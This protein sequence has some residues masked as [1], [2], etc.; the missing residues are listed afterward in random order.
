MFIVYISSSS[1]PKSSSGKSP[2]VTSLG[3]INPP[4][5]GGHVKY[6]FPATLEMENKQQL[7]SLDMKVGM[8]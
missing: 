8:T 3:L 1:K 4:Y 6:L 2:T 5:L 7:Q